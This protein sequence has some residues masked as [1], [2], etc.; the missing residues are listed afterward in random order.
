[1]FEVS[2]I[3]KIPLLLDRSTH[4]LVFLNSVLNCF[5]DLKFV[6]D[7]RMKNSM[8]FNPLSA[9]HW[10]HQWWRHQWLFIFDRVVWNDAI[11]S[12]FTSSL[13]LHTRYHKLPP[14]PYSSI[15]LHLPAKIRQISQ[16][17]NFVPSFSPCLRTWLWVISHRGSQSRGKHWKRGWV[18]VGD[19]IKHWIS[20]NECTEWMNEWM[21]VLNECMNE[22]TLSFFISGN[23]HNLYVVKTD[24][25][26]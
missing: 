1:M 8:K 16:M 19:G 10:W 4:L 7:K 9:T 13:K 11:S 25:Y 22:C 20:L 14:S 24:Q 17:V 6:F 2:E 5:I 23:W 21:D 12:L 15:R 26:R 3:K 18:M